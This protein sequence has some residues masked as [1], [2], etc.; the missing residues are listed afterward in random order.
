MEYPH[1]SVSLVVLTLLVSEDDH[2][3]ILVQ[4]PYSRMDWRG[5]LN[6]LFI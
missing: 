3:L 4:Y 1:R 6:I 5:G 2:V